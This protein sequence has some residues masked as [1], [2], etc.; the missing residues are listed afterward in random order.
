[1][2]VNVLHGYETLWWLVVQRSLNTFNYNRSLIFC[3]ITA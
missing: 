1:M 2:S 3:K